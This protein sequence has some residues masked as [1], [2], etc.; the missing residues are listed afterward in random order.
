MTNDTRG[1]VA[2]WDG[3]PAAACAI[4]HFHGY[5]VEVHQIMVRPMVIRHGWLE[6]MAN[7]MFG[8]HV[9]VLY[10]HVPEC[11]DKSLK[12][13][14]HLGMRETGRVP[15]GHRP[16]VDYVVLSLPRKECKY[17]KENQ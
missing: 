5:S 8:N 14:K 15:D 7:A 6:V 16:G 1:M 17:L 13:S 12:F 11:N 2:L 10:G 4:S 3:K 9:E